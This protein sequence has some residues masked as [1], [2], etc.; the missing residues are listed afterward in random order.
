MG[1]GTIFVFGGCMGAG[2]AL[3]QTC[4]EKDPTTEN[5]YNYAANPFSAMC[6]L[7]GSLV[8]WVFLPTVLF[9]HPSQISTQ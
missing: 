4:R 3:L 9:D 8:V 7:L 1:G 6:A 2:I 5:H